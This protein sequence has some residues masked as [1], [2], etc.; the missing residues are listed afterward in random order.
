MPIKYFD[1]KT[2]ILGSEAHHFKYDIIS[3]ELKRYIY[4]CRRK[5]LLPT[6]IGYKNSL[7]L[8]WNIYKN[9]NLTE[10]EFDRRQIVR[11]LI[12]LKN[13]SDKLKN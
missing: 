7:K 11:S 2:F 8:A 3:L 9:T 5:G 6:C 13:T 12:N 10:D 4:L 1:C